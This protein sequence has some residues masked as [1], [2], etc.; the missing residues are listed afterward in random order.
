MLKGEARMHRRFTMVRF[1][2]ALAAAS[3]PLM[4]LMIAQASDE[5]YPYLIG[6]GKADVT[7]PAVGVQL[8]GFVRADQISEGIHFRLFSRAFVIA[9]RDGNNRIGFA[10]VDLGS[11]THAMHQ[12]VVDRLRAKYGDVYSD[13]N[14]ILSATHTHSGPSGYWHYGTSGPIGSPF[15][16]EYFDAIAQGIVD[17]ISLAH[18]DLQP[19]S[20]QIATGTVKG[21]G[22]N[23]S[24]AA[25]LANPE[26]ERARYAADTDEG[27]TLLKFTDASGD[28]GM[29]NWFASHPTAMTFFN[30][31]I[32][33]DHKG[34]AS[35][36]FEAEHGPGFV[37][38]FA[39][40][41]AGDVTPNL[42]LNNTGP[43]RDDFEST[44]IIAHRQFEVARDL[45]ESAAE[46]IAGTIDYRHVYVDLAH[47]EVSDEF[48]GAG[49]QHTCPSAYG[50]SRVTR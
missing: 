39:Q 29:V 27:M 35:A 36:L 9:E 30:R 10:S 31:L 37:G 13:A 49:E 34:R 19:G 7:G 46:T 3:A 17:S 48:T 47:L 26:E 16:P 50:W 22:A 15:Y 43:G 2:V 8:W 28:I 40:S 12:E 4:A 5:D 25:Y 21:A 33:G 42:N 24:A 11:I 6:R 38:A 45:F 32:S 14:V 41:N 18:E 23:R 1:I 44:D 20:I